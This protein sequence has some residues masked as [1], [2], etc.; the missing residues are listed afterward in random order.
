M[1][2]PLPFHQQQY[3]D[4][5]MFDTRIAS[6]QTYRSL[7]ILRDLCSLWTKDANILKISRLRHHADASRVGAAKDMDGGMQSIV[8]RSDDDASRKA[9]RLYV[10]YILHSASWRM[11]LKYIP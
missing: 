8:G 7:D 4:E 6:F 9:T 1:S 10:L 2:S 11:Q 3:T 5:F